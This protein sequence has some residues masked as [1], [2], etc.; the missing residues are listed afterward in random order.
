M[1]DLEK[2]PCAALVDLR[3]DTKFSPNFSSKKI[4]FNKLR[5]PHR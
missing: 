1:R 5:Y 3:Q 4:D 2:A